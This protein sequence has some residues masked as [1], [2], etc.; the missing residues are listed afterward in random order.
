[1]QTSEDLIEK[2]QSLACRI[3][4]LNKTNLDDLATLH[5]A[6]YGGEPDEHFFTRKYATSYT[7]VEHVGFLAYNRE[8]QVVGYNGVVPCFIEY[9]GKKILA[10]QATDYMTHPDYRYKGMLIELS[11]RTFTLC[12]ELG[13]TLLFGFPN[14]HSYHGVVNRLGWKPVVSMSCF[15]VS[16]SCFPMEATARRMPVLK[17]WYERRRRSVLQ[18]YSMPLQGVANS[19]IGDGYAGINRSSSYFGYKSYR[20]SVVLRV[21]KIKIWI[22]MGIGKE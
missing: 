19:V 22:S 10:A 20:P 4:R 6:V 16:V 17:R 7:G 21:G 1:M 18:K 8:G 15:L 5:A 2:T 12:Q 14:Q 9:E 11:N 13:I 3:E